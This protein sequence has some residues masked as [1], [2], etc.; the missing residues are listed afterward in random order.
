MLREAEAPARRPTWDQRCASILTRLADRYSNAEIADRIEA[1]T[2]MRF[3]DKT[4]SERRSDLG[5]ESPR[6]NDWTSP[7]R[8]WRPWQ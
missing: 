5:L 8:R 1:E 6:N 3:K 2:G 7:L 4:I